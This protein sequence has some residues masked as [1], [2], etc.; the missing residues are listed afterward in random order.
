M[1]LR[2][3]SAVLCVT[4][5]F[6]LA[7]SI[8][9]AQQPATAEASAPPVPEDAF[10]RG[11]PRRS[12]AAFLSAAQERDFETAA[13]Y[14]D[15]RNLTRNVRN[16]DGPDL[17]KQ[18]SIVLNRELWIDLGEIS[19]DPDGAMRDGQ[20][21]FRDQFGQLESKDGTVTLLMQ[22][23]PRGDGQFIWK[24]S[25][26]TV[27]QIPRLYDEFGYGRLEERLIQ[28]L[29]DVSI[30]N[31][32]LFKWVI[33]IGS[34]LIAYPVLFLLLRGLSRVI[35]RQASPR[36]VLV[37]R[38]LTGPILWLTLVMILDRVTYSLGLGIEAQRLADAHTVDIA[39]V[40]WA[41][42]AGTNL[43]RAIL[44]DRLEAQG[45][46][47][48]IV[49]LR[50]LGNAIKILIVLLAILAWLSNLGFNISA[51]LAGLGVG[52]IA[53]ALALQKPLE[54]L[55]GAVS[56]YAQQ[57]VRVGD[58]CC[59]GD[60]EGTVE[61][62]GL[63]TTRIRTLAKTL[64]SVPNARIATDILDNYSARDHIH[65]KP[66]I[67]LSYRCTADQLRQ[68]LK[69]IRE[70]LLAH[71]EVLNDPC[72]VTMTSLGPVGFEI[73][74][75]AYIRTSDYAEYLPIAEQLNLGIVE[76][77]SRADAAFA[78]PTMTA[79]ARP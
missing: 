58:Y 56:M 66:R 45:R 13:E 74:G 41:L 62:I 57:S 40:A 12:L 29:P 22:R 55:F 39:I 76:I 47:A 8:A 19:D 24:I 36:R 79:P 16:V 31:I 73:R 1:N 15:L 49:L 52:G 65:F 72:R 43:F 75:H 11:T 17:A 20:E 18:L 7:A 69:E 67:V 26:R 30:F 51:L 14:L 50:P 35:V 78:V 42:I 10:D 2:L 59:F 71:D 44:S 37:R 3:R 32:E 34:A 21:S 4:L 63:R 46:N 6:A 25:N 33:I 5:A 53:V 38:F 9:T 61:E 27:G 54:D 28:T 23:V 68:V 64:V 48:K 77:V 60:V 70:L